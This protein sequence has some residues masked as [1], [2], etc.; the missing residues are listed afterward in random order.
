MVD[1]P[2]PCLIAG[3]YIKK[4]FPSWQLGRPTPLRQAGEELSSIEAMGLEQTLAGFTSH[5]D[6][7]AGLLL[8]YRFTDIPDIMSSPQFPHANHRLPHL[9]TEL[10]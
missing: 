7:C 10:V 3:G 9:I 6:L 1:F 5:G 2:L 8:F 4:P